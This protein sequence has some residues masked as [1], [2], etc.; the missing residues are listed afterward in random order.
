MTGPMHVLM[1]PCP[2]L[3]MP[4]LQLTFQLTRKL[5]QLEDFDRVPETMSS[6]LADRKDISR[7]QQFF[8]DTRQ[9]VEWVLKQ[10]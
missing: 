4:G 3:V 7:L 9:P 10:V 5:T 2:S 1:S 8:Q 6:L